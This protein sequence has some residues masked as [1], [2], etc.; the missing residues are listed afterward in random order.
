MTNTRGNEMANTITT[1]QIL[2]DLKHRVTKLAVDTATAA[3]QAADDET[4]WVLK[5]IEEQ[6]DVIRRRL[7]HLI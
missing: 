7:H 2:R 1:E 6:L 5:E 4:E 3:E